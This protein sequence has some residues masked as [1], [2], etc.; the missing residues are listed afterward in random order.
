MLA[1]ARKLRGKGVL[2]LNERNSD[3]IMRLNPRRLYPLVDDKALTKELALKAGMAVPDLY[4][5]I[6]HQ[7]EVRMFADIVRD[8]DS[9]VIKPARGSGGDGILVVIGRGRRNRD[10]YR[11]SNGIFVSEGEILHHISNT[12]G[13]QYSLS[14]NPD[15]ALI[16]YCVHFDPTFAEVSYQGVPDI[17]V[18]VY[19]GYPAMAMVRLPT[20][21]SDGKANLHQGAVGAGVDLATGE[22]LTGVLG[23]EV[24][25][26]HPDTG[27]HIA[28]LHIPHWDVILESSARGYDVTGLGYLGVDMVIDRDRGPLILEMNARPGLNI[29]IANGTGLAQRIERIDALYDA[30]AGAA[31]RATAA[32]REFAAGVEHQT[33][34]F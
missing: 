8:R 3:Y 18:I 17:R 32:R 23:N 28:G 29:Q 31:E 6:A 14:G 30:S 15:K 4:G 11:L 19:R 5:I 21:A 26:E 2:G 16:E 7:G 1:A 25:D 13:G 27:A 10:N 12:V 9:F 20:R 34:L 24:I 33:S 22:T